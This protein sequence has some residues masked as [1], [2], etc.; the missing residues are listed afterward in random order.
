MS[1][2][3]STF[4]GESVECQWSKRMWK[5]SRYGWRPAAIA[6][7]NSCGVLPGLVGGDHDRRAVRVVGADEVHLVAAHALEAHPDVGLDVLHDVADVERAVGVRQGGGDEQSS[8]MVLR[9]PDVLVQDAARDAAGPSMQRRA[10][11]GERV[12]AGLG[13]RG[14]W[15][16]KAAHGVGPERGILSTGLRS[17]RLA[18]SRIAAPN[19]A[20]PQAVTHGHHRRTSN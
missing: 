18:R 11:S 2:D 6:A 4:S 13:V 15:Q 1:C 17:I 20:S 16:W 8:V 5:P 14:R 10:H 7:T 19:P 12:V 3:S 9:G